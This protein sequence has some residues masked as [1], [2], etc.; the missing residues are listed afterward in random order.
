MPRPSPSTSVQAARKALG[1]R[2]QDIRRDAGING[3]E[4]SARCGWHPAKTSRLQDGHAVATDADIRA[5]C[6]ACGAEDQTTD[7]IA[8][9]RAVESMYVQWRRKQQHGLRQLQESYATLYDRT[10]IFRFYTSDVMPGVL[11]TAA[12]ATAIMSRFAAVSRAPDDMQRAIAAKM[13][14]AQVIHRGEHRSLFLLEEAVL[15]YRL[16]NAELMAG[17]LGHLL[18][19]MSLTRVSLGIIPFTTER[20]LWPVESFRVFDDSCVQVELVSAAV[21]VTTP[22]EIGEYLTTFAELREMAVYGAQARALI[23]DAISSLG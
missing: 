3:R 17:Q 12:Y 20:T 15:R 4:L 23:S 1:D 8:A 2:L 6:A 14:R 16:G 19:V 7:L 18:A 11:Q 5:W 9:S 10:R 21:N 13:D 22:T